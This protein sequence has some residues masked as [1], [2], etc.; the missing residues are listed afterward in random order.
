M[1]RAITHERSLRATR[2][3]KF[4]AI[5]VR[6][7][8]RSPGRAR[9][10]ATSR[11]RQGQCSAFWPI[12][13]ETGIPFFSPAD[14]CR[15]RPAGPQAVA[16]A[17]WPTGATRWPV[18]AERVQKGKHRE[19]LA[20]LSDEHSAAMRQA[21]ACRVIAAPCQ[22]IAAWTRRLADL[23]A[24]PGRALLSPGGCNH[25]WPICNHVAGNCPVTALNGH[26]CSHSV[27]FL[28][29]RDCVASAT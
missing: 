14:D 1:A 16:L 18:Q 19:E 4:F 20:A 13:R 26:A 8:P 7:G 10:G 28:G 3:T 27:P 9:S 24:P 2:R 29:S 22:V 23:A 25:Q 17:D 11:K 21:R 15:R 5:P 6:A 12:C